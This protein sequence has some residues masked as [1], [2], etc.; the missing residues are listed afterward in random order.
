MVTRWLQYLTSPPSVTSASMMKLRPN[1]YCKDEAAAS[2][3]D[4]DD[5]RYQDRG[6][7]HKHDTNRPKE[8]ILTN[9]AGCK[10][11]KRILFASRVGPSLGRSTDKFLRS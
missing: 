5:V 1:M 11:C 8:W 6:L 2:L 7:P 3:N 9:K 10:C 4:D